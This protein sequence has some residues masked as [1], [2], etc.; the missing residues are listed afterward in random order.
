VNG[1]RQYAALPYRVIGRKTLEVMLITTRQGGCWIIPKGWP[2][3]DRSKAAAAAQEAV[4][5]AGLIGRVKKRPLGSF[6]YR[7]RR[8]NG[9]R[10]RCQVEVFPLKVKKQRKRWPERKQRRTRWF[11]VAAAAKLV[12]HDGLRKI[13]RSFRPS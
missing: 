6:R 11:P 3:Q 8:P 12:Q 5:E 1:K 7:K 13:I 10:I 9:R 2:M 4:E